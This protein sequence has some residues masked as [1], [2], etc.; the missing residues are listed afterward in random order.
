MDGCGWLRVLPIENLHDGEV[1]GDA[2]A[3]LGPLA[4]VESP[5]A[6]PPLELPARYEVVRDEM[7]REI[8]RRF[9]D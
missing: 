7:H 2:E 1:I 3:V 6:N 4:G 9:G 5:H 8:E